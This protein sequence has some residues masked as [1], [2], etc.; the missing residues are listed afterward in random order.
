MI[1]NNCPHGCDVNELF[2]GICKAK[3]IANDKIRSLNYGQVTSIALDPIE[4][5]P[6]KRF[7]PGSMILSIGSWGCNMT[8]P[9]CQNDSISRGSASYREYSPEDVIRIAIDQKVNGNIGIA[10]TYNEALVAAD[11]VIDTAKLAKKAGLNNVLVT[12]GMA[13]SEIFDDVTSYMDAMNIDLK[14][15]D[16]SKYRS[17]GGDYEA[18]LRNIKSAAKKC[19]VELTTLIV[20]GFNDSADEMKFEAELIAGISDE[21]PLHISRFFPAGNLRHANPTSVELLYELRDI[22]AKSLKYV[23]TGNC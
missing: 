16:T 22:A 15:I 6:L 4:K 23:F 10:Y 19:H 11:F 21:I 9:W 12:N 20:P 18:I 1:C 14:T 7:M 8:C 17:I 13:N 5:K 3:G 2:H